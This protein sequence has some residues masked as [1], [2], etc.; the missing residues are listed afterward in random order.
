MVKKKYVAQIKPQI[1]K[2]DEVALARQFKDISGKFKS[3]MGN[4]LKLGAV[5]GATGLLIGWWN[6]QKKAIDSVN[7]SFD[8]YLSMT[9]RL[10]TIAGDLGANSGSFALTDLGLSTF[11]LNQEDRDKLYSSIKSAVAEGSIKNLGEGNSLGSLISIQN[12]YKKAL[13]GGDL[14]RQE[15]LKSLT[16]LRGQKATEFLGGDLGSVIKGLEGEFSKEDIEGAVNRGG[17]L[18]QLQAESLAKQQLRGIIQVSKLAN[19][20]IIKSQEQYNEAL[21]QATLSQYDNY[22]TMIKEQ[23]AREKM[24]R[25]VYSIMSEFINPFINDL[26]TITSKNAGDVIA[27]ILKDLIGK[28]WDLAYSGIVLALSNLLK[29]IGLGWVLKNTDKVKTESEKKTEKNINDGL[30]IVRNR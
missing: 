5:A 27:K 10:S 18:E 17:E 19:N 30:N 28:L 8:E 24:M 29:A 22:D 16:G 1:A 6:N 11:G 7:S 21:K 25:K 15:F 13:A 2:E 3:S 23:I 4:A 9:D 26:S 12:D 14:K 20:G